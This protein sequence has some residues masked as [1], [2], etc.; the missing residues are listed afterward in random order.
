[1]FIANDY[2]EVLVKVV[3]D[4]SNKALLDRN[5]EAIKLINDQQQIVLKL[6]DYKKRESFIKDIICYLVDDEI[7]F[8]NNPDLFAF[9][10]KIYDLKTHSFIDAKPEQYTTV[11]TG[12]NYD[13]DYDKEKK[14]EK[15]LDVLLDSIF[16]DRSV[17][18]F[19]LTCLS[20]GFVGINKE[21][22]IIANGC[23]GNGKGLLNELAKL[24]Y[25]LYAYVMPSNI[26]LNPLKMGSNPEIANMEG[27]RIVFARE[28]DETQQLC[29]S[30]IKEL[31]GG[32]EINV[33]MNHSNECSTVLK[34]ILILECNSKPK[35]SEVGGEEQRRIHDVPFEST[36]IDAQ[37]Y[38]KL[39]P[40]QRKN[41]FIKNIKYKSNDWKDNNKQA[42]F[43]ILIEYYKKYY[44]LNH[45]LPT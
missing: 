24:M 2:Y 19:Y 9:K 28:P 31:T 45:Q 7:K 13:E 22:F 15:E 39:E 37:D 8:D 34:I 14:I 11:H 17:K 23:G 30:T 32:E 35:L 25:G 12:Y 16:P 1:M 43:N 29:S 41:V 36:F 38:E 40:E 21:K 20:L 10:N 6:A 27:K 42:L 33:R 18:D 5:N 26:L 3:N 44:N 4:F